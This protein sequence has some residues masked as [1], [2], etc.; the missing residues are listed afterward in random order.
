MTNKSFTE[1]KE[2]ETN[3]SELP[4][5]IFWI[6]SIQ[7]RTARLDSHVQVHLVSNSAPWV[8]LLSWHPGP[9]GT[10]PIRLN[11][12]AHHCKGGC[13]FHPTTWQ[14]KT[15]DRKTRII[16]H[17]THCMHSHTDTWGMCPEIRQKQTP[18]SQQPMKWGRTW[19]VQ[20]GKVQQLSHK[21]VSKTWA[22][23][24]HKD[25]DSYQELKCH[26]QPP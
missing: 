19:K 9:Q 24:S 7:W 6:C 13:S 5:L 10:P 1:K 17:G 23:I 3:G 16:Q 21:W 18:W 26:L 14:W 4:K 11:W 2:N 8:L 12:S 25:T 15:P 20:Q 22:T